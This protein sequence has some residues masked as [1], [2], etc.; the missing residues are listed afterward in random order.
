MG[1]EKQSSPRRKTVQDET[2]V[3]KL[4]QQYFKYAGLVLLIWLVGYFNFS[5]SWLLLG[6]VVYVWKVKYLRHKEMRV[7]VA[8]ETAKDERAAI[9][10]RMDDLP[11]WVI[12]PDVERAEWMNKII[13]QMWP[14]V[15]DYVVDYIKTS[16]EPSIKKSLPGSLQSF[17]FVKMD[18][19]DIPPRIGG[20]KVY[21]GN[22][23]RDEIVMD[24]E[25]VY[26]SDADFSVNVKGISAGL[27]DLSLRGTMRVVMKPL[28]GVMPLMGG[29]TV[30][31][32]NNPVIDFNLT[33]L[34]NAFDIPGLNDL[35][36]TIV[37]ENVAAMMVLPNRIP[38]ALAQNIDLSKLRY[39]LPHGVMRIYAL[40]AK[41]LKKAD[42]GLMGSGGKSDPYAVIR[43]GAQS[44]K[45]KVIN[46]TVQPEWN[47]VFEA[48]VDEKNGQ[49]LE[50]E[51][52]DED[53]GNKDDYLGGVS[54]DITPVAEKKLVDSW[55][56]LEDVKKGLV[57]LKL[58]WL[59]LVKDPLALDRQLEEERDDETLSS[60]ML[61]VN[62]DSARDLPR[63]KKS[64]AEPCPFV[65]INL[66]QI[67]Q[68]S[69]VKQNTN[70]PRWEENFRFFV[71]NPNFQDLDI[72]VMDKK[73]NCNLGKLSV[74][75]K[76]LLTATDMT[77][78]QRF[79]LRE[80]GSTS[81][82]ALRLCLRVLSSEVSSEMLD[83]TE[84][85]MTLPEATA[86]TQA[87]RA[88]AGAGSSSKTPGTSVDAP[89]DG[90]VPADVPA[91]VE[92][93]IPAAASQGAMSSPDSDLRKRSPAA[94]GLTEGEY[95]LGKIQITIRYSSP[96]QKLIVVIHKCLSLIACDSDHLSDPYVRIYLLPEKS[97]H[98]KRKTQ[99][100]KNNLNP[101]FDET[102]E[103]D[104]NPGDLPNRSMDIAVKNH[105]SL[106][107]T[108]RTMMGQVYVNLAE[109]DTSKASTEWFDLLP[110]D[111]DKTGESEV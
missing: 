69:T 79:N 85:L 65:Q 41:D 63:L 25:I 81:Q 111:G 7:Q 91:V 105:K 71:H 54:L 102:F 16:L 17:K 83:E 42:I 76:S 93:T 5:V 48:I 92:E 31:F 6:L 80:S 109:F 44:F 72:T 51:L 99:V 34:A 98:N 84:D 39:P 29:V 27:K 58:Q 73:S 26:S 35:L 56:P 40:G 62:L 61:F 97:S 75:I 8:Q 74:P 86:Q 36:H 47:Q 4:I 108:S 78:D 43:V 100:I 70:E 64:L 50:V 22:V 9:L 67:K 49:F 60:C 3:V 68:E 19:G 37:S 46:N 10:A 33:S 77:L 94:S 55:L 57:H 15:G 104:V 32:L 90:L 14:Y 52:R 106:F 88:A 12:F 11:S 110:E 87:E 89:K 2:L 30:F 101:V 107:S 45:T 96:R 24:L 21:T 18:L 28:I 82:I 20:V 53:P 38:V 13:D 66:G 95:G 1:N 103:F 23:R 59:H